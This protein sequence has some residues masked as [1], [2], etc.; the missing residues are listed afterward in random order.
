VIKTSTSAVSSGCRGLA[1]ATPRQPVRGDNT[2][3]F[4]EPD[5]YTICTSHI[6]RANLTMRMAMR[7]F[8]SLANGFSKKRENPKA[9]L[10]LFFAYYNS[11][12]VHSTISVTP[13]IE[14]RLQTA[15]GRLPNR[16]Q[17]SP[18]RR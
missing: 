16:S 14:A 15:S 10:A 11:C 6:E 8:T 2:S 4:G 17:R 18:L 12:R 3:C 7:R 13:A 5:P 1:T 9:M